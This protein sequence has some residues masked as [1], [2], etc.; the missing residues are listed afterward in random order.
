MYLG[1]TDLQESCQRPCGAVS[2]GHKRLLEGLTAGRRWDGFR[3]K[4]ENDCNGLKHIEYIKIR[5]NIRCNAK[6]LR[7]LLKI[8]KALIHFSEN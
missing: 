6:N 4:K 8:T 1:H 2:Q 5:H 3:M 7:V